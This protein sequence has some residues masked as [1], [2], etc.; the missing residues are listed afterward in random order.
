ME[1]IIKEIMG[2]QFKS[3][4][5]KEDITSFF[6]N[7]VISSGK[8]VPLD[9]FTNIEKQYKDSKKSIEDLTKQVENFNNS[10]LSDEELK[11]KLDAENKTLIEN[12]QKQLIQTKVEKIFEANGMKSEEY[13]DFI[14]NLVSLDEEKSINSANSLIN[15]LNKQIESQVKTQLDEKLKNSGTL[16][17]GSSASSSND[18][19]SETQNFVD[20]IIGSASANDS[21]TVKAKEFYKM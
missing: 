13:A 18:K 4:M 15:V 6:E 12:L 10:K 8:V 9:K 21:R 7:S 20:G 14:G 16:P 1:E 11:A 5:T 2:D 19:K 3:G 17:G